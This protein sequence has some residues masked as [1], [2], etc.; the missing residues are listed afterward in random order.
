MT[1]EASLSKSLMRSAEGHRFEV[2]EILEMFP[3]LR[4]RLMQLAGV[5][6]AANSR[7]SRSVAD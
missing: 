6:A 1:V 5:S 3:R 2:E 4:E 7:C